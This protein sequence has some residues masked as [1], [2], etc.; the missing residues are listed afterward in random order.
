[1]I[2]LRDNTILREI[3][4]NLLH[5]KKVVHLAEALDKALQTRTD[6]AYKINY[7][8]DL[9]TVDDEILDYLLWEK[10]ITPAE[11]LSLATTREQKIKLIRAATDLHR[12]KGTPAAIEAVLSAL[13][14]NGKVSEWFEYDG[15]P[16]YFKLNIEVTN[17]GI[18]ESTI[19]LLEKLIDVYKNKRSWLEKLNIYFTSPGAL[20][21][22]AA[23]L[24]GEEITVYPYSITNLNSH[25]TVKTAAI[26]NSVEF[27]TIYP[28]RSN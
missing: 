6:W 24:T 26:N 11:G 15:D 17:E 22:G 19:Q 1:M 10:H 18:D 14:L 8:L 16:Y 13:S 20:Y 4:N 9:N 12:I 7:A 25:A 21:V 23:S 5:D 27:L 3:P 2:N 28:E